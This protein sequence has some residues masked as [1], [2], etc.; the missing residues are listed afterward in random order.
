MSEEEVAEEGGGGGGSGGSVLKKYGPLAA[1]VLLA[2]VVLAWVVI[3]VTIKDKIE[4]ETPTGELLPQEQQQAPTEE[5]EDSDELPFYY[6]NEI[7]D[8]ITANPAGTNA[9]RFVVVGVELGLI[10]NNGD[11]DVMTADEVMADPELPKVDANLGLIK[12]IILDALSSKYI[13]Q[14][15]AERPDIVA[16][17]KEEL[18][19]RVFNR[20]PWGDD[21]D[22]KS[23]RIS[24]VIF[25]TLII[26]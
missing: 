2:Q 18:N 11:G 25:T 17:L 21:D 23:I 8:K 14:I 13:D 10:G 12:S 15:E 19:R 20:I 3:Q 16:D 7:L 24:D 9:Q 26:Q 22:Q 5:G 1:I 6:K 4:T